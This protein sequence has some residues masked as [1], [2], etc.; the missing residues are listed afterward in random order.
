MKIAFV[1]NNYPPRVGGVES[2]VASLARHLVVL[3]HGVVVYTLHDRTDRREEDGITVVRLPEHLRIGGVLGFPGI[4]TTRRLRRALAAE[5]VDVVSV[6]TRFFPMSWVGMRAA[7]PIGIP[8]VHTEHGSDH[9]V[10]DSLVITQ[11]S[12][13]V[14]RTVGRALLRRA[15]TVL[16]VSENVLDFVER[17][18]GRRGELFFNAIEVPEPGG[19]IQPRPEHLVFVGRM[20]AGKGWDVFLHAV[21]RLVSEGRT[22]SAEMLGDGADLERLREMIQELG[23]EGVVRVRGRV[24]AAEVRAALRGATLVNPT[25]L[26]EGFQTTLLEALA[27]GGAVVTYPVPGA[28][29]LRAE[30]RPVLITEQRDPVELVEILGRYLDAP[31]SDEPG[32]G[33][34][35]WT[36]PRRAEQYAEICAR[37][38][39]AGRAG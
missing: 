34:D 37:T 5:N 22:V 4:G 9:V 2:H 38:I 27:E 30:G 36:W 17:L 26:A 23:L 16:G 21:T 3:G 8:V 19:V 31:R 13:L 12:R 6:H 11:A 24:G 29:T 15:D 28:V 35:A 18:S 39:S 10:S 14:D 25:V 33:I 32:Q 20:V 1:V 7:R